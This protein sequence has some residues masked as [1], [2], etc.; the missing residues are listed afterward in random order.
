MHRMLEAHLRTFSNEYSMEGQ[1]ISK[2][3]EHFVA[4]CALAG[5]YVGRV[6]FEN[7]VTDDEEAGIDSVA[8][9]ID[10]EVITTPDEADIFFSGP[11]RN[12]EVEIIFTQATTTEAFERAKITSFADAVIDFFRADPLLP[13]GEV[14]QNARDI[15]AKVLD[16]VQ[17]IKEG[18]PICSLFFA[19]AGIW[20]DASELD[21]SMASA[22]LGLEQTGLFLNV[23][24]KP[25]DRDKLI[26]RWIKSKQTIDA[27]LDVKGFLPFPEI[28]GVTEAYVAIISARELVEKLIF[29]PEGNIRTTVFQE[30]VRAFLGEENDVNDKI[31]KTLRD[32]QHRDRFCIL[33]N[34]ITVVSPDIRVQLN[35]ISLKDFQVVNGCQTSHVLARNYDL[36][37]DSVMVTL[38]VIEATDE[39]ILAEVVEATNSQTEVKRAQFFSRLP[40]VKKIEQYFDS[41]D[42][43]Q[44][45]EKKLYFERRDNQFAGQGI[46][47]I[48]VFDIRTLARAY[49]SVFLENP[50]L[51][52][53]YPTNIFQNLEK[54]LYQDDHQEVSY[55]TAALSYYRLQLFLVSGRLPG[56]T[57][58]FKWHMLMGFKY[59][60]SA[61]PTP[62]PNARRMERYCT[63]LQEALTDTP[64]ALSLFQDVITVIESLGEV[65]R[66]RLKRNQFTAELRDALNLRQ[67]RT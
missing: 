53:R 16:N 3:F 46:P 42:A 52:A 2:Q 43:V 10:E 26:D 54:S 37:G 67:P 48:R 34:G 44:D 35:T 9:I 30:N 23:D 20:Q 13:Q 17:K 11:R 6:N 51:A 22:K 61:E 1:T 47:D 7:V 33:N 56:T 55:Y 41:F 15:F 21:A 66:D 40:V 49:A 62:Q 27:R 58:K 24:V 14:L 31:I 60:A 28:E 45:R 32:P 57:T 12:R 36:L 50:H 29:D 65:S 8:F 5:H 39:D 63:S 38:K 25:L 19:S 18:R 59:L 64:R 4:Y